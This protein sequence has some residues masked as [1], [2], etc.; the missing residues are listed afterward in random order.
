MG[1]LLTPRNPFPRGFFVGAFSEYGGF[2]RRSARPDQSCMPAA[3]PRIAAIN[4]IPIVKITNV[5]KST[6]TATKKPL[7]VLDRGATDG[8][9]DRV[10]EIVPNDAL[11]RGID[12]IVEAFGSALVGFLRSRAIEDS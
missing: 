4:K 11:F 8:G 5:P 2:R 10:E 7:R 1:V 6:P 9:A 12:K 3:A